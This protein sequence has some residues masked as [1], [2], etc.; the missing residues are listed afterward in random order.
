MR[1]PFVV[2]LAVTGYLVAAGAQAHVKTPA[3]APVTAARE[4]IST[5]DLL[6]LE[7]MGPLG[8]NDL[9]SPFLALSPD[10]RY[11]AVHLRRADPLQN[12]YELTLRV[13][14]LVTG[15]ARV[16]DRGGELIRQRG[17]GVHTSEVPTGYP[18]VITPKWSP[19]GR[20]IAYVRQDEGRIGVRLVRV[21][22][23]DARTVGSGEGTLEALDWSADGKHLWLDVRSGTPE[24]EARRLAE[25]RHGY[26]YDARFLPMVRPSPFDP[27]QPLS[28]RRLSVFPDGESGAATAENPGRSLSSAD[29]DAPPAGA[30]LSARHGHAWAWTT[31][32][33]RRPGDSPVLNVRRSG[34]KTVCDA[35]CR[36]IVAL[37][38][39]PSG[40]DLVFWRRQGWRKAALGLYRWSI[41][42]G[43]PRSLLKTSHLIIGCQP[44]ADDLIC[45]EEG[46]T[47][48]RRIVRID[49][50][51]GDLRP[52]YDPNPHIQSWGF[53]NVQ[54]L[55]WRTPYGTEAYGDLVLPPNYQ[56]GQKRPLIIVGY[57]SRGFLKGGTGD[58]YPIF[59]LAAQ[60]FA[61][62]SVQ[63]PTDIGTLTAETPAEVN[64]LNR[65]DW[66]DF[67]HVLSS[68]E[69][70][71]DAVDRLG[72]ID[73]ARIGLTGF[74]NGASTA[75]FALLNSQRFKVASL[76]GCCEEAT[77]VGALVGPETAQWLNEMGYP[78]LAEPNDVF[79]RPM[80]WRRNTDRLNL[81]ILLQVSDD[82]YLGALEAFSALKSAR[83]PVEMYVFP[84]EHHAKWQPAHRKAIYDRNIDWFRF[85]LKDEVDPAPEKAAQYQRWKAMR[86]APTP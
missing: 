79:W 25:S 11:V 33:S 46:P 59:P 64:Q 47:Q 56:A 22:G 14:D 77:S 78:S 3:A 15:D 84:D 50:R 31:R 37:W 16:V 63:R 38:W 45:A 80:S 42:E 41:G 27:P 1:P 26:L 71:I 65:V 58:E 21:D 23:S 70:G 10:G 43:T 73:T 19:D 85:W 29:P 35:P 61:V 62:L 32:L 83:K 68:L 52:V 17:S 8:G 54:R 39:S 49:T 74:S 40:K 7:E 30:I 20:W 28:R 53:G 36:G 4:A 5:D 6:S 76:S 13:I 18:E 48:P 55:T 24:T 86:A 69:A 66:V 9:R 34:V 75:Q 60:G 81:P 44:V 57:E 2:G 67:R 51:N 12:R 72:V 82:E